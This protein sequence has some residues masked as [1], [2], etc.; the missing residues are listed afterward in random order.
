MTET[1]V[2]REP[3]Q[4]V[5][6]VQPLCEHT[7]GVAPCTA[8][9]T[10][11]TKCFN[12][13][14]TCQDAANFSLQTGGLSLFFSRGNV[15]DREIAGAPYIIPSLV[16]VSTT[17]TRINL[18]ASNQDATGLG[19]RAVI[20][21]EFRDHPHSDNVVDPYVSGRGYDPMDRG[22]FWTKWLVRNKYRYNMLINVYEGYAG[23]ALS[24]MN[25]RSY[26]LTGT[27]WPDE[28]GRVRLQGKDILAKVEER[29]AQAPEASPGLLYADITDSQTSIE[30][31]GATTSDYPAS[32]TLRINDE[33]MTY[34]SVATSANGITFTISARGS[35]GTTAVA[36]SA[37]DGVQECLRYTDAAVDT[38]VTDLLTTWAG[39]EASYIDTTSFTSEAASHLATY[40]LSTVISE[41]VAVAKLL[42]ELQEQ[43]G[44]FIWWDER[45]AKIK[46]KAVRGIDADPPTVTDSGNIIAGS[47]SITDLPKSRISQ[48]WFYY[49]LRNET[50]SLRDSVNFRQVQINADLASEAVEQFGEKSVRK[51]FSRWID[52]GSLAFA[53]T[54]KI[55]IR[56][57]DIP[58][59]CKFR[60]DAKDRSHW[61]GDTVKISHYLDV[62]DFG[63][64]NEAHW[65]IISAEE[66]E[67]GEV[68]EYVAD[69]TTLYGRIYTWQANGSADYP[70]ASAAPFSAAYWGDN[71]GLLSDG[72]TSARWS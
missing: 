68:V 20:N 55:I 2:G 58:R 62:D 21:I 66:V 60:M 37:D 11:P 63:N 61:V 26:I 34:S 51:I 3:V 64:R 70:G 42:S 56:Y 53:T 71:N 24:A 49:D 30:V 33:L 19:N 10:G 31:A 4:I 65:T 8:T 28:N 54:N 6:L 48:V 7:F 25:K 41:P 35:D 16:S 13:R 39:V 5:E 50:D 47:F 12:T 36:H 22:S 59:R 15:A 23:Q 40:I 57:R 18:S 67:P 52:T 29:K 38:I 27:S 9:G 17:P 14:A 32:G 46:M 45:S 69:D 44:F 43:C 1:T 72:N